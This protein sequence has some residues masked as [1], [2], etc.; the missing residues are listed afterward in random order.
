M[1]TDTQHPLVKRYLKDLN[2]ALRD[3]PPD[4]RAEIVDEIHE[5]IGEA[6]AERGPE[7]TESELRT[8]LDQVGHPESIAEDAR[9]RFGVRR[10]KAGA[11]EGIAIASLLFGGLLIPFLGWVLGVILLWA[12]SAWSTRDKILGTLVVPGGL[13]APVFFGALALSSETCVAAPA[14]RGPGNL[15]A[16]TTVCTSESLLQGE[17]ILILLGIAPIV[18]AVYLARKAFRA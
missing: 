4:R 12:S 11:M 6:A 14:P 16:P 18:V 7:M 15:E 5:H 9:E 1:T 10:R 17:I 3:L 2:R 13:A 8:V